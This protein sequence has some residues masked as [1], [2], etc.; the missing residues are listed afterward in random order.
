MG[1]GG[2]SRWAGTTTRTRTGCGTTL[3]LPLQPARLADLAIPDPGLQFDIIAAYS[4]FTSTR[5]AET[6]VLVRQLEAMLA[7]GGRLAFT[8]IDPHYH[9]WPDRYAGSN[10]RWRLEKERFEGANLHVS[11]LLAR[12]GCAP[13]CLLLNIS[14]P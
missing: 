6:V 10:L 9:S 14:I 2:K 8:F 5:A 13:Y 7:P 3:Q 11:R 1:R 4:V 12:A